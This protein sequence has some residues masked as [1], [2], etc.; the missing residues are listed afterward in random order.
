MVDEAVSY[1][2]YPLSRIRIP[3]M[4]VAGDR[5]VFRPV[6]PPGVQ[7]PAFLHLAINRRERALT[8]S[9]LSFAP[10]S[11]LDFNIFYGGSFYALNVFNQ[12]KDLLSHKSI[13]L[14]EYQLSWG[15]AFN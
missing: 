9:N 10:K 13:E 8:I 3:E 12:D 1:C 4:K 14:G 2:L 11:I 15:R 5:L 7:P 6:Q